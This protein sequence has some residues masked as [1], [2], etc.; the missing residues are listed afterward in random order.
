MCLL[1][2]HKHHWLVALMWITS[3]VPGSAKDR[4]KWRE[5]NK[6]RR[7]QLMCMDSELNQIVKAEKCGAGCCIYK[8]SNAF[9]GTEQK[10]DLPYCGTQREC[11]ELRRS[12]S[13]SNLME[14]LYLVGLF[15]VIAMIPIGWYML[16]VGYQKRVGKQQRRKI[17]TKLD[18]RYPP[19]KFQS[20]VD[21]KADD[22]EFQCSEDETCCVCLDK[23]QGTLVRKLHC[24]HVL[25]LHCFDL[26]CLHVSLPN[27]EGGMGTVLKESLWACPLC[28]RPALTPET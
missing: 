25:H 14:H 9:N 2:H 7:P 4:N 28:K 12:N 27:R 24:G 20:C 6:N 10:G 11:D 1:G 16:V 15:L 22:L 13:S 26:W 17:C 23:L 21:G 8:D 5:R 18:A 3:V 19:F